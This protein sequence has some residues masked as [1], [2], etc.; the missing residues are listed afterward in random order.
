MPKRPLPIRESPVTH[1]AATH[2]VFEL[3]RQCFQPN[4]QNSRVA[5]HTI[6]PRQ[7]ATP[8]AQRLGVSKVALRKKP[9]G[10]CNADVLPNCLCAASNSSRRGSRIITCA[11]PSASATATTGR[12]GVWGHSH[13]TRERWPVGL[14]PW[15]RV[16]HCLATWPKR[17]P[18]DRPQ[19]PPATQN[20]PPSSSGTPT[21]WQRIRHCRGHHIYRWAAPSQQRPQDVRD[22]RFLGQFITQPRHEIRIGRLREVGRAQYISHQGGRAARWHGLRLAPPRPARPPP[23]PHATDHPPVPTIARACLSQPPQHRPPIHHFVQ[24][25]SF[26]YLTT[27]CLT[28]SQAEDALLPKWP[29]A[30]EKS[31][32][33]PC[34]WGN[35]WPSQSLRNSALQSRATLPPGADRRATPP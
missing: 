30:P 6:S 8:T 2:P 4:A 18:A 32:T 29:L 20:P 1:R 16:H 25:C 28:G 34:R 7:Q 24:R 31:V 12:T 5:H 3:L 35:P 26:H 17:G 27:V 11:P 10:I 19:L 14:H 9:A 15:R 23:R 13:P 21:H 33:A 22:R